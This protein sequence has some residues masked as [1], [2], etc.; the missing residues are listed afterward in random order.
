[1]LETEQP[2]L[3]S[4]L[5]SSA[6]NPLAAIGGH[7]T[8]SM[9]IPLEMMRKLRDDLRTSYV[10]GNAATSSA[11][12]TEGNIGGVEGEEEGRLAQPAI[13]DSNAQDADDWDEMMS[14]DFSLSWGQDFEKEEA[15][16]RGLRGAQGGIGTDAA[17]HSVGSSS[18]AAPSRTTG[19]P[20]PLLITPDGPYF[21]E[22]SPAAAPSRTTRRPDQRNPLLITPD[23]PYFD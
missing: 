20:N 15:R 1:M 2:A 5:G 21:V 11:V 6:G 17:G 13:L 4:H 7:R 8:Q 18:T 10:D 14:G 19:R 12:E 23:G 9:S 22:S 16:A 3:S